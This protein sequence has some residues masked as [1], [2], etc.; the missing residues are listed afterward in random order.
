M[1]PITGIADCC[2]RAKSGHATPALTSALMKLRRLIAS[3][4]AQ[5]Q[6]I[7]AAQTS[8]RKGPRPMSALGQKRTFAVQN[9]MSAIPPKADMCGA[10]AYVR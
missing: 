4:Q 1:Y 10:L 7:V 8:H 6:A 2:A 3:P 5:R 9:V